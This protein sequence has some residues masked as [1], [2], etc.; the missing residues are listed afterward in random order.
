MRRVAV[1]PVWMA[2]SRD[3]E[4]LDF[5][6]MQVKRSAVPDFRCTTTRQGVLVATS[7]TRLE[8]VCVEGW[9]LWH[10]SLFG[11]EVFNAGND[12]CP[13]E[14]TFPLR[15]DGAGVLADDFDHPLLSVVGVVPLAIKRDGIVVFVHF[16]AVL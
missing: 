12:C 2:P 8:V 3:L 6:S 15:E 1:P 7:T 9:V 11:P 5:V 10:G 4:M 14:Q 16:K 13:G